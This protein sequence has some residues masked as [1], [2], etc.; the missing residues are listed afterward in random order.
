MKLRPLTQA[1]ALASLMTAA[2]FSVQAENILI[3]AVASES[4]VDTKVLAVDVDKRLVTVA[5]PNDSQVPIQLSENAKDLHNLKVG[6]SV[7]IKVNRSVA[8][9]LD[10]TLGSEPGVSKEAGVIRATKDNPNPGGEAFR[11]VKVTSK[12][13]KIDL[14]THEVTLLPPEG[15]QKVVKVEDPE[16]QKKMDKLQVGQTVDMVFTDVLKITTK[17]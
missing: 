10:T 17:H 6:D 13:T 14:K 3:D 9:V 1:I 7:N 15:A 12:I 5:G 8:T 16:L 4:I 2:S 11:Q